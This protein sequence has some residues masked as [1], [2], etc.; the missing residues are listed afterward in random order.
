MLILKVFMTLEMGEM[1]RCNCCIM[2]YLCCGSFLAM[3]LKR[4]KDGRKECVFE[5]KI[6]NFTYIT[7]G[8]KGL[9]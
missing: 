3:L 8:D 5:K 2:Q 6:V 9:M 1:M 7:F 4:I